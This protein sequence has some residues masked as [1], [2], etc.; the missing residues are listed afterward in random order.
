M[1]IFDSQFAFSQEAWRQKRIILND[2][3]LP[4]DTLP[5]IEGSIVFKD[6]ISQALSKQLSI[7]YQKQCFRI[8]SFKLQD[9]S[10]LGKSIVFSYQVLHFNFLK[11]YANHNYLF[12]RKDLSLPKEF[13]TISYNRSGITPATLWNDQLNKSG[14]II[15]GISFGNN[16]NLVVNSNLNLQVSGKI[17][18]ELELLLSATDNNIP[19]QP[20][21]SSAQ[22]QEFDQVYIQLR[23][24][25]FAL[26]AGDY[27]LIKPEGYFL[28]YYKRARGLQVNNRWVIANKSK[29]STVWT[30]QLSGAISRGKFARNIVQGIEGN[31][32][33]YRLTGSENELFIIIL[34]GTEKVFIDGRLMQRGQENDYIID[35]NSAEIIFTSKQL[36][37]KDKRIIIEFQY[38]EKNYSRTLLTFNQGVNYKK[39]HVYWNI[40]SEQDNKNRSL[41]QELDSNQRRILSN[42]GD[43]LDQAIAPGVQL[44]TFNPS[45]VLYTRQDTIVN[46]IS[47]SIF[48]YSDKDAASLFQVKFSFVGEGKGQYI[49]AQSLAN[50]KVY[51]WLAPVNGQ[52][53]GSYEPVVKLITPKQKQLINLGTQTSLS[54]IGKIQVEGAISNNDQNLFSRLEEGN[55]A[56]A[57][58]KLN[59]E[60]QRNIYNSSD[61]SKNIQVKWMN[62]YELVQKSFSAIERFRTAEFER[63]WNR[64]INDFNVQKGNLQIAGSQ[65]SIENKR[66]SHLV[67]SLNWFNEQANFNG[68]RHSL[69]TGF[70]NAWLMFNHDNAYTET[71][72]LS[73]RSYF[74]RHKNN[75][76][77]NVLKKGLLQV[78]DQFENNYFSQFSR[79]VFYTAI[80]N[81]GYRFWDKE[82]SLG[83]A[84]TIANKVMV[85]LKQREEQ[86]YL[87]RNLKNTSRA[88]N[89]GLIIDIRQFINHPFKLVMNYRNLRIADTSLITVKPDENFVGRIEYR[90][91]WF[92]NF[93][94]ADFFYETGSGLEQRREYRYVEVPPG[95][96]NFSWNDYNG[97]GIKELNEFENAVFND[98]AKY[99][100][101]FVQSNNYNKVYNSDWNINLRLSPKQII[102]DSIHTWYSWMKRFDY[103]ATWQSNQ[104]SLNDNERFAWP[105]LASTSKDDELAAFQLNLNQ[106]IFFNRSSSKFN[107]Q[108][109]YV[110]ND[111]KLLLFNGT[112]SRKQLANDLLLRYSPMR[113]LTFEVTGFSKIKGNNSEAFSNR[114]YQIL[115]QGIKTECIFQSGTKW[116][117]AVNFKWNDKSNQIGL[118]E[119]AIVN[120]WG[121][122]LKY[123]Q[124]QKGSLLLNVTYTD[125]KINSLN[126]NS[127]LAFELLNG[128]SNGKNFLWTV[129]YSVNINSFL[130]ISLNYNGRK[131]ASSSRLVHTGGIQAGA[132]F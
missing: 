62:A 41:Q 4:I 110:Y 80:N 92:S 79:N 57:A 20:D 15:R 5:I 91:Q 103:Q 26:T 10:I 99:I 114:N 117:S 77:I 131:I 60:I 76:S 30:S 53:K 124:A 25:N 94:Q 47:Y 102:K 122:E 49:Q 90:P 71:K 14:S 125:N 73:N 48:K 65:I 106:G 74:Y 107:L 16:Q 9:S 12:E 19:I 39:H 75:L 52:L 56:G 97:N 67:Y 112:D 111:Q 35:Y 115:E 40:Y 84:D 128:L 13:S 42:I 58:A 68:I 93:I 86:L 3:L 88:D 27:Q 70:K 51:T 8:S 95:Q 28:S 21:G 44:S 101:V 11:E 109:L 72:E 6:S 132:Y 120:E 37:T 78:K 61:S 130:Q 55:D 69:G 23:N 98:Q 36:I 24:R 33:P 100:R 108:Y 87:Q 17:N 1:V 83:N 96:G 116:R 82:V 126:S 63:D 118:R 104:K 32:G 105:A 121:L 85:F 29:D 64:N 119:A 129:N 66:G 50:G 113:F 59:H 2:T 34:S 123:N 38:S 43:N 81:N 89:T 127:P 31:Q 22:L 7:D 46:G 45:L 54:S 18:N